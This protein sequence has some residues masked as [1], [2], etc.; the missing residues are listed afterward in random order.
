[1]AKIIIK[2]NPKTAETS[3]KAEGFAGPV[4]KTKTSTFE[5]A[6]GVVVK[7][8][9]TPEIYATETQNNTLNQ[10]N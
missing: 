1:M 9:E 5:K 10:G 7:D 3:I 6:L 8:E 4:C 2:I